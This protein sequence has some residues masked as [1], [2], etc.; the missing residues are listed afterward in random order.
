MGHEI[1]S[2]RI[3]RLLRLLLYLRKKGESGAEVSDILTHSEYSERRALQD[4]IRLLRDEYRA[5]IIYKRSRPPRYYLVDAGKI[6]L[7]LK[8]D[9]N[10]VAR[11]ILSCSP[12]IKV[13]NF[14]E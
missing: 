14:A 7:S 1:S 6:L 10:E 4:D 13:L 8:F 9:V 2:V 12:N 11:W 3:R 5:E